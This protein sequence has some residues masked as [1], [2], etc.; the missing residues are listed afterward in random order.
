[1]F[2]MKNINRERF[3]ET[4]Q[5]IDDLL[6]KRIQKI[7]EKS[8]TPIVDQNQIDVLNSEIK[9][10]DGILSEI[11]HSLSL[12][13]DELN[14]DFVNIIN[15]KGK[16]DHVKYEL[17]GKNLHAN[18]KSGD[19]VKFYDVVEKMNLNHQLLA[20]IEKS[21]KQE[22]DKTLVDNMSDEEALAYY[23]DLCAKMSDPEKVSNPA[24]S[25][26]FGYTTVII[27]ACDEQ[28][29]LEYLNRYKIALLAVEAKKKALNNLVGSKKNNGLRFRAA[30]EVA[31]LPI[32]VED[33]LLSR[34]FPIDW[35]YVKTI[36]SLEERA[37]Y[38]NNLAIKIAAATKNITTKIQVGGISV[39]VNVEDAW[40]FRQCYY[41]N[42]AARR[43]IL[44]Q[45][46]PSYMI[47]WKYVNSLFN[48]KL[49][50]DYFENLCE[51]IDAVK[52]TDPVEVSIK[53]RVYIVNKKDKE[54]F[55]KAYQEF[56]INYTKFLKEQ[57]LAKLKLK[58]EEER[59]KKEEELSFIKSEE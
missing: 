25:V 24:K 5:K 52:K 6:T 33:I 37:D 30:K 58:A 14:K 49:R 17:D 15:R 7:I 42:Q 59:R 26:T 50:A 28:K 51:K 39:L 19:K 8:K 29:Y 23:D 38:F 34:D 9:E 18:I 3:T 47:D 21:S 4:K 36:K 56:E 10:L 31:R 22:M 35:A 46:E 48:S 54:I 40:T 57:K 41:E 1:M 45:N 32:K 20:Y 12:E 53:G 16:K 2:I 11:V 43:A 55:I 27:N 13:R 44:K